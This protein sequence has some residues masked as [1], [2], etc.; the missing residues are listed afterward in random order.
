MIK[1]LGQ[2]C[3]CKYRTLTNS[4]RLL[5]R[6]LFNRSINTRAI[7]YTSFTL[8]PG[9]SVKEGMAWKVREKILYA[10]PSSKSFCGKLNCVLNAKI[11]RFKNTYFQ[12]M[13]PWKPLSSLLP[14]PPYVRNIFIIFFFPLCVVVPLLRLLPPKT[15]HW[16]LRG[17]KQAFCSVE[18]WLLKNSPELNYR[19]MPKRAHILM[20]QKK[21]AEVFSSNVLLQT[22]G[23]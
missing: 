5:E 11:H 7:T 21:M 10:P 22:S 1:R 9:S 8:G 23:K 16:I 15:W 13:L 17:V 4:S 3:Q 18:D 12:G 19:E 20:L 14:H 6:L 2:S